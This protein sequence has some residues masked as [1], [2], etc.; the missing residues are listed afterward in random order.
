MKFINLFENKNII[1][2]SDDMKDYADQAY[3]LTQKYLSLQ[4]LEGNCSK[5][6]YNDLLLEPQTIFSRKVNHDKYENPHKINLII[7]AKEPKKIIRFDGSFDSGSMNKIY[8][9]FMTSEQ[10]EKFSDKGI[11]KDFIDRVRHELVHA[12][13]PINNDSKERKEYDVDEKLKGNK[14]YKEYIALPWEIKANLSS[15]AERNIEDMISKN[16]DY[17]AIK[18]EIEHWVPKISHTNYHKEVDYYD[19]KNFW[20]QYK[21]MMEK[22]LKNKLRGTKI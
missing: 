14:S 6:I 20:K 2:L 22:I 4:F 7:S 10:I 18:K 21:E 1:F 16:L 12:I 11:K 17:V 19:D 15:M 5:E 9:Y 3:E 8:I 13:D